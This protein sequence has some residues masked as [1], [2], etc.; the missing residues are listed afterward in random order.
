MSIFFRKFRL[1]FLKSFFSEIT[2]NFLVEE[3][4]YDQEAANKN[5][6]NRKGH[7][8]GKRKLIPIYQS[9]DANL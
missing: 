6:I 3:V 4:Y 2:S 8:S 1:N 9:I 7:Q 5:E